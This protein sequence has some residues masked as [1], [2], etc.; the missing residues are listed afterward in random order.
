MKKRD[1]WQR[2]QWL[3]EVNKPGFSM[4]AQCISRATGGSP[5]HGTPNNYKAAT[6]QLQS[7]S[8]ALSAR[9]C[10]RKKI[11][12]QIFLINADLLAFLA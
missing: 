5:A 10:R 1:F 4:A 9:A 11:R 6:N 8:N 7:S 12:T 3:P 2:K